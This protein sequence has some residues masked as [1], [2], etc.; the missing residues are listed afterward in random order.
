MPSIKAAFV[1]VAPLLAASGAIAAQ[2]DPCTYDPAAM[3]AM[4]LNAFDNTFNSGWRTVGDKDGCEGAA[5]NLIAAYRTQNAI[6][7]ANGFPSDLQNLNYHEAQLRAASGQIDQAILLFVK[8]R[9]NANPS[10]DYFF[11]ATIAFLKKDKPALLDARR[12]LAAVPKPDDFDE[13]VAKAKLLPGR[14]RPTWPPNL[15]EVDGFIACFD[16]PY[17]EA[18]SYTCRPKAG[19]VKNGQ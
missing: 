14:P 19:Q 2:T 18:F 8:A 15:D 13:V 1:A 6:E 16:K 9:P 7:L 12:E 11:N 17:K 5:A 4:D 10:Q 3:M